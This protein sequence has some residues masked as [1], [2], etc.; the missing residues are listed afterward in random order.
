MKVFNRKIFLICIVLSGC[1][2]HPVQKPVD[3]S[4]SSTELDRLSFHKGYLT[5]N[6]H[7]RIDGMLYNLE[8]IIKGMQT[9]EKGEPSLVPEEEF[10]ILTMKFQE[11]IAAKQLTE[12]LREAELYLQRIANEPDCIELISSKLYYKQTKAGTGVPLEPNGITSFIY[13]A[14]TISHGL[15]EL[16]FSQKDASISISLS[17]TIPGFSQGVTGMLEGEGRII[18]IHPDLA[19]G[20][21]GGKMDPNKLIIIEVDRL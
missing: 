1:N 10:T 13:Q 2:Y 21:Y 17:D 15:E 6:E 16:L 18:Y 14:K 5:W 20:D 12:N 3:S 4:V 8:Q 7:C 9:A 19:Y 11:I